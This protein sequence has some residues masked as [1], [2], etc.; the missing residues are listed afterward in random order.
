MTDK[1]N[2]YYLQFLEKYLFGNLNIT[3]DNYKDYEDII[4]SETNRERFIT[5][6]IYYL[7]C[8]SCSEEHIKD[9]NDYNYVLEKR[10]NLQFSFL[11]ICSI[12][13]GYEL[14]KDEC[15]LYYYIFSKTLPVYFQLMRELLKR[16]K[17]QK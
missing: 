15:D 10:R 11:E 4:D 1:T 5:N 17:M 8:L 2:K 13:G 7:Y 14:S 9:S 3:K 16:F 12:L 6:F